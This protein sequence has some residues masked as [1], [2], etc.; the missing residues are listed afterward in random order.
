MAK[1]GVELCSSRAP[2]YVLLEL[3]LPCPEAGV[4]ASEMGHFCCFE[5]VKEFFKFA[6]TA[7]EKDVW[8][9]RR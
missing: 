9:G 5:D 8:T 3:G 2:A 1:W 7:E 6:Y 4:R